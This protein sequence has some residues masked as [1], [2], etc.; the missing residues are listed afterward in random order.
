MYQSSSPSELQKLD[1]SFSTCESL[2]GTMPRTLSSALRNTGSL[3]DSK[4]A[5]SDLE[6]LAI[7]SPCRLKALDNSQL[8]D[9]Q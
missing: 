3:I 9:I 4:S 1:A 7:V 6:G 2:E 5:R 8:N